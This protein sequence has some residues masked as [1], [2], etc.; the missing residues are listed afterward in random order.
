MHIENTEIRHARNGGEVKI[1]PY[2]V[3]GCDTTNNIVYEFNGCLYHK[4]TSCYDEDMESPLG[5][6]LMG[7]LYATSQKRLQ[8]IENLG[9]HVRV[10]WECEFQKL[11]KDNTEMANYISNLKILSPLNPRDAF[12]GGRTDVSKLYH[13]AEED[14][15]IHYLDF[16]SLYPTINK[17]GKMPVGHPVI[18][19]PDGAE[20]YMPGKYY[21]LVKCK[22][23]P[24]NYLDH[25]ILPNKCNGK[26]IF[27]LCRTCMELSQTMACHH[28]EV[29]RSMT[30]TWVSPELDVAISKGY[31]ILEI[32]EI[33]HYATTAEYGSTNYPDGLFGEYVNT[34]LKSKQ[35][36]SG[37]PPGV[38]TN[39]DKEQYISSYYAQEGIYLDK[40]KIAHNPGQRSLAKI[41]L[42]R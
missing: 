2:Y 7:T 14:E 23:L 6:G 25:A 42:N 5:N 24:P 37:W 21:G 36:A 30:G 32:Y 3:D 39:E 1:G 38:T 20:E 16:V 31:K 41:M 29:E 10:I 8:H 4:C 13:A 33:W 26:L 34:M 40:D 22:V 15:E 9:Y 12:Y 19:L 18:I 28:T 27:A 17:Y 35:E 11:L